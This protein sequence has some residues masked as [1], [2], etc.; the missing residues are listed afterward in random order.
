MSRWHAISCHSPRIQVGDDSIPKCQACGNCAHHLLQ[1]LTEHPA[2]LIPSLP[3]DEPP[4]KLNLSW[5][6]T[7]TYTR[8]KSRRPSFESGAIEHHA[9]SSAAESLACLK[10]SEETSPR[11]WASHIHDRTLDADE[12]RLIALVANENESP[13]DVIHLVLETYSDREC[14]EYEAVSYTWGGESGDAILRHPVYVGE[15]WDILLQT[16]NCCAMLRY[17]RPSRG[18]RTL[19]VDAIC[20]NQKDTRERGEQVAKMGQIYSQCL[21]VILWLGDDIAVK[22]SKSFPTRHRLHEL[23]S[24]HISMPTNDTS[25]PPNR[26]TIQKLLERR[27]FSRAWVLQELVLAPRVVIPIGDKIFSVDPSMTE[28][29]N[30]LTSG[31]WSWE[32]TKAPW[33]QHVTRGLLVPKSMLELL[34]L[35]WKSKS[36]DVRDKFYAILGPYSLKPGGI[37]I[38]PDYSISLQHLATGFFAHCIINEGASPLLLKASGAN[39]EAGIPSWMPNWKDP[40]A[41]EKLLGNADEENPSWD[42]MKNMMPEFHHD[43]VVQIRFV[44]NPTAENNAP[45]NISKRLWYHGATVDADSGAMTLNL[46]RLSTIDR[47]MR[48]RESQDFSWYRFRCTS[49]GGYISLASPRKLDALVEVEDEVYLFDNNTT[50]PIYLVLRPTGGQHEF[51]LVAAC[52]HLVYTFHDSP[53][54]TPL[55][56]RQ[57]QKVDAIPITDLQQSLYSDL[58]KL[59]NSLDQTVEFGAYRLSL[60]PGMQRNPPLKEVFPLL[61]GFTNDRF[62]EKFK[63]W[64][65]LNEAYLNV[66]RPYCEWAEIS[67]GRVRVSLGRD[68]RDGRH[69]PSPAGWERMPAHYKPGQVVSSCP[70]KRIK[71]QLVETGLLDQ[72]WILGLLTRLQGSNVGDRI[73]DPPRDED[74]L[75]KASYRGRHQVFGSLQLDGRVLQVRI[76]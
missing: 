48:A 39:A 51:L 22:T 44:P 1:D 18:E 69:R 72:P 5:P 50:A 4:G 60:F 74:H 73:M 35:A 36:S 6:S 76:V 10:L 57:D 13:A 65:T 26:L 12:F 19:W 3:P 9:P 40:V 16:G 46:T 52:P 62:G 34:S 15:Y 11:R 54:E 75:Q 56:H 58:I 49:H 33:F 59:H 38:Q 55:S 17:L 53:I 24:L 21:Q 41:W 20:I 28:Y 27:Y 47:F 7:I 70:L 30:Q 2:S 45:K 68:P 71:L 67:H 14:P 64:G 29:L 31:T 8:T 25:R 43:D 42:R 37:Q 32:Q 66:I 61:L 23:Q 63:S